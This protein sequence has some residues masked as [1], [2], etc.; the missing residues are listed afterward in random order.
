MNNRLQSIG[1]GAGLII[2]QPILELLKITSETDL[3]ISTD[4][5][6]LIITPVLTL[7]QRKRRAQDEGGSCPIPS[8]CA[9]GSGNGP[10]GALSAA[11]RALITFS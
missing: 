8:K 6:S 10:S 5:K 2:D 11:Q 9:G 4:G 1:H 3:D 7:A